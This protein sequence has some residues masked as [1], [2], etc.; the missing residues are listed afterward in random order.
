[1]K[2][3]F[4]A[5]PVTIESLVREFEVMQENEEV[6]LLNNGMIVEKSSPVL[7]MTELEALKKVESN[8]KSL[9]MFMKARQEKCVGAKTSLND[10]E[11][12]PGH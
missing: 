12:R 4:I 6:Y 1:M 9:V 2:T 5:I 11:S 7:C 8:L 3:V 10:L